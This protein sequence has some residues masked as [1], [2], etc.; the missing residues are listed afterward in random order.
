M[1]CKGEIL[2]VDHLRAAAAVV[3]TMLHLKPVQTEK[4]VPYYLVARCANCK[5]GV[6]LIVEETEAVNQLES[7]SRCTGSRCQE[8]ILVPGVETCWIRRSAQRKILGLYYV[9]CG[10]VGQYAMVATT[11]KSQ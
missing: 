5:V 1:F 9:G 7:R 11:A 2:V 3:I 10:L 4:I 6:E 8:S